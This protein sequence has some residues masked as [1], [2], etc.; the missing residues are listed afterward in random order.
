LPLVRS[1]REEKTRGG[2]FH[3]QHNLILQLAENKSSKHEETQTPVLYRALDR[4]N[5][6]ATSIHRC[7]PLPFCFNSVYVRSCPKEGSSYDDEAGRI[8]LSAARG[9]C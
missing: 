5:G 7:S 2:T 8:T 6:A 3:I 1:R 9:L 4:R